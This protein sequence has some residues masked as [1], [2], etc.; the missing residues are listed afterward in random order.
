MNILRDNAAG[1]DEILL[2]SLLFLLTIISRVPFTSKLLY[3]LDSVQFALAL[4]K[5]DITVHQPHPPGYFLYVML[6]RFLNFFIK[7]ANT[8]LVS[9]SVIF[10]SL[11]VVALYYVGKEV[12]DTRTGFLAGVLA[13]TSPNVWFHGEV[14]L[15]YIVE[16]FFTTLAALICWRVYKGEHRYIWLSVIILGIA[17]GIRQNTIVFL[18][19]LWLFSVKGVPLRKIIPSLALLGLVCLLWFV[20]MVWMT[21]GWKVYNDAFQELWLFNTGHV[22][23]FERGWSSFRVFS[24]ALFIFT[25]YGIGAGVLMLGLAAY[26]L[27]R[28]RRLASLDPDK[29]IFFSLWALPPFLFYL[30]IFIHPA[31]PGYALAFLPAILVLTAASIR[32]VGDELKQAINKDVSLSVLSV[33]VVLNISFFLFSAYPVSAREIRNHDRD[34]SILLEG[35]RGYEPSK[36]AIF[37]APYIFFG[38]RQIMY[39]LPEYRTYQ[40]DVRVAPGGEIRK[41]FWGLKRETFV[42]DEVDLPGEVSTFIIPVIGDDKKKHTGLPGVDVK[43]LPPTNISLVSGRISLIKEIFPELRVR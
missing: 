36:T 12:F 7:D 8:T 13:L 14:A 21:G 38:Y 39:Y 37:V 18:M 1:N 2:P 35:I 19:P 26:S 43:E 11:T 15:S 22:S 32:Y 31:N 41:T 3:H 4:D 33:V 16:A 10:S 6:G 5:Y 27:I 20:P 42:T 24:S 30:L 23:V 17:G 25:I 9:L 40:V 34:L 29:M 28:H